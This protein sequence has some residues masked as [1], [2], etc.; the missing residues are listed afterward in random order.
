MA[1]VVMVVVV[2]VAVAVVVV[3]VAAVVV[4][5]VVVV[6][7]WSWWCGP[8][9]VVV[10]EG[11]GVWGCAKPP[12]LASPSL[13]WVLQKVLHSKLYKAQKRRW[14]FQH[15]KGGLGGATILE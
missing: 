15:L 5:V 12:L 14:G 4:V 9:V 2:A 11:T 3:V 6:W 1:V 8:V 10:V 7:S 13:K